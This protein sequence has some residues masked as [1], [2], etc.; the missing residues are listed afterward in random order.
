MLHLTTAAQTYFNL[1]I[2]NATRKAYTASIRWFTTFCSQTKQ[3]AV[4]ASEET[5]LLFA[6][7]LAQQ[8][9]SYS[10]IQVYL[11]GVRY[12]HI[13][14]GEY[15]KTIIQTTPRISQ[16]LKGIRKS[17]ATTQLRT[18]RQPITFP[19]MKRLHTVLTKHTGSLNSKMIWAACCIAY[20]GLLRVNEFTSPNHSNTTNTLQLADVALDSHTSPK[21]IQLTLHQSKTDQF[22]KGSHIFLGATSHYVCPVQALLQYLKNRGSRPGPLFILTNRKALTGSMFRTALKKALKEL[23]LNPSSFNTHSFRIGA[24][25]SAKQA[26]ISDSYLKAMGRWRSDAYLKYIRVSPQDM[27]KLSKN[28]TSTS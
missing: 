27:A 10:T 3:Q 24:A 17:Q 20:F 1:G 26:G 11:S 22:R 28:L 4:P 21:I 12:A 7:Y 15:S 18:E 5:L 13:A 9:L 16:V 14:A 23:N 25:T 8:G 6:T 19:I 2:S